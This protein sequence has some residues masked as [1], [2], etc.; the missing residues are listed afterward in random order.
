MVYIMKRGYY[1]ILYVLSYDYILYISLYLIPQISTRFLKLEDN[2][3]T[4]LKDFIRKRWMN[5]KY[6]IMSVLTNNLFNTSTKN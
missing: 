4:Y 6:E 3:I 2:F 5:Q 1:I